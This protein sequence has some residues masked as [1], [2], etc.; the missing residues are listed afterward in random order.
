MMVPKYL[1][2]VDRLPL[3]TKVIDYRLNHDTISGSQTAY[4]Q[5]QSS[6]QMT[7]Q[8]CSIK[9]PTTHA[10]RVKVPRVRRYMNTKN[11]KMMN[12]YRDC[13]NQD[14]DEIKSPIRKM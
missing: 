7:L 14:H 3:R 9:H 10:L 2:S 5:N 13:P 4:Q 8:V 6:R 11:L 1:G 12:L